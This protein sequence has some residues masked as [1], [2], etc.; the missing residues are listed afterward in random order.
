MTDLALVPIG[1]LRAEIRRREEERSRAEFAG[2]N[3][4]YGPCWCGRPF[5]GYEWKLTREIRELV[6]R[7]EG[8]DPED[9]VPARTGHEWEAVFRCEI[10]HET[11]KTGIHFHGP[12]KDLW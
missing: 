7:V 8:G 11:V 6:P 1:D 5:C 9:R 2:L 12:Q 4:L 10:R 3:Q